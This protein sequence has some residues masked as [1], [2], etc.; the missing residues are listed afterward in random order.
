MHEAGIRHGTT[1]AD[2]EAVL[3]RTGV[4]VAASSTVAGPS[5]S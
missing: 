2:V 5:T 3:A 4:L 1:P